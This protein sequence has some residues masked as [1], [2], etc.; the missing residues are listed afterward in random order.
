ME[1]EAKQEAKINAENDAREQKEEE[2][3]QKKEAQAK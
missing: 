2:E 3:A 1:N